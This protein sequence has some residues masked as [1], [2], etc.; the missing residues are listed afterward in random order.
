MSGLLRNLLTLVLA[1][2]RPGGADPW[3]RRVCH[4]HISPLDC[5]TRVLK[6]DKYL[7]L[8]E[9]AQLDFLVGANLFGKLLRDGIGFVN[10]SQLVRFARPIGM[11]SR[12][13]VETAIVFADDKC[14]YFSH[15]L[16]VADQAHGEVLVKMKFKRGPVTVQPR[17]L[18]G[19]SSLP[20]PP[21]LQ[22][23]DRA[24]E[25]MQARAGASGVV[26]PEPRALSAELSDQHDGAQLPRDL[27]HLPGHVGLDAAHRRRPHE[28]GLAPALCDDAVA[29]GALR[30]RVDHGVA[31]VGDQR[32]VAGQGLRLIKVA[33]SWR[34]RQYPHVFSWLRP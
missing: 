5:G 19:D 10:A 12:V 29:I 20:K 34:L 21:Q 17:Q 3:S 31:G 2:F 24:L 13:R 6:S 15:T 1:G 30:A 18:L 9:A 16:Y 8:A 26:R 7:Q 11:F 27:H 33:A 28:E 14:A 22:A 23:W 25:A 4:F 32:P